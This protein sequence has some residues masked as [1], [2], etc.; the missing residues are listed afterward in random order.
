MY[1]TQFRLRDVRVVVPD[2]ASAHRGQVN[3]NCNGND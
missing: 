3:K 1:R 2:E